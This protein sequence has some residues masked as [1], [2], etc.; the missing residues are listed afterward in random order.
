MAVVLL[1]CCCCI[2]HVPLGC[3]FFFGFIFL[4]LSWHT[5]I[6]TCAFAMHFAYWLRFYFY[7]FWFRSPSNQ[8][9]RPENWVVGIL[10]ANS[11]VY[12]TAHVRGKNNKQ[13]GFIKIAHFSFILANEFPHFTPRR[14]VLEFQ[15]SKR[16]KGGGIGLDNL[17]CGF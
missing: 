8:W 1:V 15:I 6:L 10:W 16:G 12:A 17:L 5:H 3:V 13:R 9:D 7:L 14:G 11:G 2:S 4:F